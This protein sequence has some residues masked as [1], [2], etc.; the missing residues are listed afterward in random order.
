MWQ[1]P[2][3]QKVQASGPS[4]HTLHRVLCMHGQSPSGTKSYQFSFT[5]T[6]DT[7]PLRDSGWC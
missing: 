6:M 3:S 7:W 5:A 4:M 2:E 1:S